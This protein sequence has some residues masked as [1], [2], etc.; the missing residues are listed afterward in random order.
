VNDT[1]PDPATNSV[2]LVFGGGGIHVPVVDRLSLF[3]D[4]RFTL[5]VERTESGVFLFVPVRG[6]LAWRF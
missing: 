3:T 2:G 5:Q 6:G 4:V 1:F